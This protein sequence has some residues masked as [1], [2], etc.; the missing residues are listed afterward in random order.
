MDMLRAMAVYKAFKALSSSKKWRAAKPRFTPLAQELLN[1]QVS[2]SVRDV[3]LRHSPYDRTYRRWVDAN[4]PEA[5]EEAQPESAPDGE[6]DAEDSEQS[7]EE[8]VEEQEEQVKVFEQQI[9]YCTIKAK[10][11]GL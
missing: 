2:G 10:A 1:G 6:A 4:W 8:F 5:Q 7:V 11:P 9:K 3:L